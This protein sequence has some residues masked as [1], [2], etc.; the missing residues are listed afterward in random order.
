MEQKYVHLEEQYFAGLIVPTSYAQETNSDTWIIGPTVERYWKDGIA[1][2][3]GQEDAPLETI[4]LYTN[5][6]NNYRGKYDFGIGTW[7]PSKKTTFSNPHI[8]PLVIPGGTYIKFTTAPGPMPEV[9]I[10]AWQ[11]I[12]HLEESNKLGA[13]RRYAVD[14]EVY[15]NLAQNP[16]KTVIDIYIGVI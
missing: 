5:Y 4:A 7:V 11:H 2:T 14:F 15:G 12:W 3:L 9:V 8:K 6:E 13:Q 16:Q 10:Q 1:K